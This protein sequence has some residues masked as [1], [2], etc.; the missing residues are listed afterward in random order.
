M[1]SNAIPEIGPGRANPK[2]M[3]VC[4]LIDS[5]VYSYTIQLWQSGNQG[6]F[7]NTITMADKAHTTIMSPDPTLPSASN[8]THQAASSNGWNVNNPSIIFGRVLAIVVSAM[9]GTNFALTKLINEHMPYA[10]A[11]ALRFGFAAVAIT[12]AVLALGLKKNV[13]G[14][15]SSELSGEIWAAMLA[16]TE[17]GG[18]N[19]LGYYCQAIGML[20]AQASKVRSSYLSAGSSCCV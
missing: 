7:K 15:R 1:Y 9:L 11:G 10:L 3:L 20:T 4:A 18:W 17:I 12:S 8:D 6:A 13:T 5:T 14:G 19:T 16:G 2:M